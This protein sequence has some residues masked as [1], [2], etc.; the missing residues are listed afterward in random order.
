MAEQQE[1]KDIE[2][3]RAYFSKDQFATSC[4]GARVDSFDWDT[5]TA[6]VS[7]D[8]DERHQNAQGFVM[9]G[10]FFALADFALAIACNVSKT[11]SCSVSSSIQYMSR[12]KGARLIATA[13][14]DRDGH[15]MGYYTIDISDELGTPVARMIATAVHAR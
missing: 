14:P 5:N 12:A 8:L 10:V 6:V 7:M 4:L 3:I 9:G 15:T 11:P 1:F 2:A 13:R